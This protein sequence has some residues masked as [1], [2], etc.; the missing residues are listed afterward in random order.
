MS[1]IFLGNAYNPISRNRAQRISSSSFR[2][3]RT[4]E[5]V[6][7]VYSFICNQFSL[8]WI[9]WIG[10]PRLFHM[11]PIQERQI[12]T[13]IIKDTIKETIYLLAKGTESAAS[14]WFPP[15]IAISIVCTTL[16]LFFRIK[17]L[18]VKINEN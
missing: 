11:I 13:N 9:D 3:Q 6:F 1:K 15:S 5:I 8:A 18:T 4:R 2:K 16:N 14:C 7:Y 10:N 12:K 17:K